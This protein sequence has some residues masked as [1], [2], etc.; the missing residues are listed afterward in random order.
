MLSYIY[1][2]LG[3]GLG[4]ISR[5]GVGKIFNRFSF[6][7]FPVATL[8]SNSL[9]CIV[10]GIVLYFS[11]NVKWVSEEIKLFLIVGYCGGFST[12][13]TFSLETLELF[14][15]GQSLLAILNVLISILICFVILY[16]LLQKQKA[17]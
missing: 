12:F 4:A 7:D 8:I 11:F 2:F 16:I 10:M 3:G 14:K 5:F 13:S 6:N 15:S 17:A 9:S 1:V